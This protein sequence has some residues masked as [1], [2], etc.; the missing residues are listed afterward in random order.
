[1]SVYTMDIHVQ[2]VEKSRINQLDPNN[3]QFGKLYA[4]HMLIANYE[5]DRKSVV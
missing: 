3:I 4:D 5:E 2:K 1:M